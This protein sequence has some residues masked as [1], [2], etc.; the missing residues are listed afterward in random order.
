MM[1]ANLR[2]EFQTKDDK[3]HR[4]FENNIERQLG[5][6]SIQQHQYHELGTGLKLFWIQY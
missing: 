1:V 5:E 2:Q 3:L 6:S 4:V